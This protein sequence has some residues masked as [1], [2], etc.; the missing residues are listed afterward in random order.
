MS[1]D[2]R[3]ATSPNQDARPAGGKI[4][5]LVLHGTG[6]RPAGEALARLRAP[7]A[8]A[9]VHYLI[10]EDGTVWRLV[11]EE[12]RAWHAGAS[13]WRGRTGL[14]DRS[15]GIALVNESPARDHRDVPVM[16]LSVLCDLCLEIMSRHAVGA[17]DIVSFGDIA[18]DRVDEDARIDWEG[19]ARNGVG[20]WPDGVEDLGTGGT[21]RDAA[22]LSDVRAAL[23]FI[24]Y[25]VGPQGP[26]DPALSRVLRAFQRHWR[27]EALNGQADA[28]TLARLLGVARLCEG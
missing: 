26:L 28:G 9:S 24:G 25:Q 22:S 17:R 27:P 4:D 23:A 16:Q 6:R 13:F 15:I 5:M 20:L 1:L 7:G 2:V 8:A 21:V 14:D 19:L 10:E 18:P 11:E 3:T 12:R